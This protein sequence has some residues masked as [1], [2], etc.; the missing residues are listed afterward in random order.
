MVTILRHLEK[1]SRQEEKDY[2]IVMWGQADFREVSSWDGRVKPME[3]K[4]VKMQNPSS[5]RL[6]VTRSDGQSLGQ[7]AAQ[8][9]LGHSRDG[10][11]DRFVCEE[12]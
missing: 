11:E 8:F 10:G 9:L 5:E 4:S 6:G 7:K 12:D 1:F 2:H 3:R